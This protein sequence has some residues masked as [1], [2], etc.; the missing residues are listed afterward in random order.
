[1]APTDSNGD[2]LA[3]VQQILAGDTEALGKLFADYRPTLL[4]HLRKR[5]A[6]PTDAND[7]LSAIW[8]DFAGAGIGRGGKTKTTTLVQFRGGSLEAWLKST[9]INR[10]KDIDRRTRKIADVGPRPG[11]D[12]QQREDFF[13]RQP[14]EDPEPPSEDVLM[15]WMAESIAFAFARQKSKDRLILQLVCKHEVKQRAVAHLFKTSEAQ[16]CRA[17]QQARKKIREDTLRQLKKKEPLVDLEWKDF[18]NMCEKG[19]GRF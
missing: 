13:T 16:I 11:D 2:D 5:G 18:M 10:W 14:G 19:Y 17:V 6:S 9:V 12:D 7:A 4:E 8:A 3:R 1:M 15:R